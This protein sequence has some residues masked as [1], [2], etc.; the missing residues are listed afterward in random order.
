MKYLQF[1]PLN[2][3]K[4]LFYKALINFAYLKAL[5]SRFQWFFLELNRESI[6]PFF[7]VFLFIKLNYGLNL[8]F[9][10]FNGS[11]LFILVSL[12]QPLAMLKGPF[13]G[14]LYQSIG[15]FFFFAEWLKETQIFEQLF[16]NFKYSCCIRLILRID[17]IV[18]FLN[19][20]GLYHASSIPQHLCQDLSSPFLGPLF[21]DL[22]YFLLVFSPSL[23]LLPE[24][25]PIPLP[26]PLEPLPTICTFLL[27]PLY[28]RLTNFDLP[29]YEPHPFH[30]FQCTL[31]H[32]PDLR[33]TY[34]TGP[35]GLLD[36]V[37]TLEVCCHMGEEI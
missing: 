5:S 30:N 22:G 32:L 7:K 4:P 27:F 20:T 13:V 12:H 18:D 25:L 19:F 23:F 6:L 14:F 8:F 31:T 21:L 34:R 26:E 10:I 1:L 33:L 36:Q 35:Q 3:A 11:F 29:A 2:I 28:Y 37:R 17:F 24:H 9:T 16:V 15:H